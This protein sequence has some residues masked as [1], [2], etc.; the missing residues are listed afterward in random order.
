M[1]TT[2]L[3]IYVSF[4]DDYLHFSV[5]ESAKILLF[6]DT[7]TLLFAQGF[8]IVA[9]LNN[10]SRHCEGKAQSNPF[11]IPSSFA[12]HQ[13]NFTNFVKK[14]QPDAEEN[15]KYLLLSDNDHG[16]RGIDVL[17]SQSGRKSAKP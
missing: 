11:S 14:I 2:D 12:V 7:Q 1:P 6:P 13:K 8:Q 15:T 17:Y 4:Y 16:F 10:S 9:R 3:S 5:P